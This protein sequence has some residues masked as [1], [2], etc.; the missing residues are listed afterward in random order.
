MGWGGIIK[1]VVVALKCVT[2]VWGGVGR[3]GI[4]IKGSLEETSGLRTVQRRC[5]WIVKSITYDVN[6]IVKSIT[7]V[8]SLG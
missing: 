5:E 2:R 1:N 7:Y 6:W 8:M 4:I 3:G